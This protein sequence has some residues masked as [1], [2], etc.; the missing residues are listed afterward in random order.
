[1]S[2]K[3]ERRNKMTPYMMDI[4]VKCF[5]EWLIWHYTSSIISSIMPAALMGTFLILIYKLASKTMDK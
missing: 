5:H 3:G 1:M 2:Q 4:I